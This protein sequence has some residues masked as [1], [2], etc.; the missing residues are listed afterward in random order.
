MTETNFTTDW[1]TERFR[2]DAAARNKLV[3]GTCLNLFQEA[4]H[5]HIVDI[6]AGHGSNFFYLFP[7]IKQQQTWTFV[8][9]NTGLLE[10]SLKRIA[11][12][13]TDQQYP[14]KQE[15][16]WISFKIGGKEIKV[17]GLN[18]SFL[19]L[20]EVVPL[21]EVDLV[22]AG[23]V[24]DLLSV[25]LFERFA[26]LL[27][28]TRTPLLSTINY[29]GMAMFPE[30]ERDAF[31]LQLYN[32]HMLR[33]QDFGQSMGPHCVEHMK[34]YFQKNSVA[35]ALGESNWEVGT[36]DHR[37][38]QFLLGFMKEAIGELLETAEEQRALASWLADK[39][40]MVKKGELITQVFH[41]DLVAYFE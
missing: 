14:V 10:A 22:T 35:T 12:F 9:L 27:V 39:E 16:N 19:Q 6:G 3:E 37:M 24:F 7:K 1:L 13:A 33:Q 8:E 18:A 17:V 32:N 30:K 31:Y 21:S 15:K 29:L 4:D 2:F 25:D 36:N 20:N 23:A 40:S 34:A 11:R 41:Q 26:S 38:H 5:L 28:Q